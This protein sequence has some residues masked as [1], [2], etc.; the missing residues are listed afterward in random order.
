MAS[1]C[2][3][4]IVRLLLSLVLL[5]VI[6][7]AQ[8]D[9]SEQPQQLESERI[10][11]M[12]HSTKR[13]AEHHLQEVITKIDSTQL[14]MDSTLQRFVH[15]SRDRQAAVLDDLRKTTDEISSSKSSVSSSSQSATL[16][17]ASSP[18]VAEAATA[19][20]DAHAAA[21]H[22]RIAQHRQAS[23]AHKQKL[24]EKLARV[25]ELRQS[26]YQR[27][28]AST[29]PSAHTHPRSTGSGE[30]KSLLESYGVS[31]SVVE[32]INKLATAKVPRDAIANHIRD[33]FPDRKSDEL[34]D[35]VVSALG[36]AQKGAPKSALDNARKHERLF[37]DIKFQRKK[38]SH[39]MQRD[40][41]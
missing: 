24:K 25:N 36:A 29:A 26:A 40:D 11:E 20:H 19:Q 38:S 15:E 28:V 39:E 14:D 7:A 1:T 41:F 30:T 12:L 34:N 32:E 8:L 23:E 17:T 35:I 2:V 4:P 18:S 6:C 9:E 13:N 10:S 16:P 3:R 37:E 27:R 33:H 31:D 22:D 5:C 21:H